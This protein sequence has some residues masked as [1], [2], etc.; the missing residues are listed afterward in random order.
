MNNDL[1]SLL[2]RFFSGA[3]SAEEERILTEWLRDKSE[4]DPE[5]AEYYRSKWA[6]TN[7]S[8]DSQ[9]KARIHARIRETIDGNAPEAPAPRPKLLGRL[10][11]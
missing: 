11:P 9:T 2:E 6:A 8:M 5:L 3:T 10:I 7:G 1:I 4:S